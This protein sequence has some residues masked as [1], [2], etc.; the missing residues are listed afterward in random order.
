MS[1]CYVV[2][3]N[4]HKRHRGKKL[5]VRIRCVFRLLLG[6]ALLICRAAK[7]LQCS[8]FQ[9]D[10][11][12]VWSSGNLSKGFKIKSLAS[13]STVRLNIGAQRTK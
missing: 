10:G 13:N 8:S 5:S 4:S 2:A 1:L 9:L 6:A 7:D 12:V 3:A 11:G